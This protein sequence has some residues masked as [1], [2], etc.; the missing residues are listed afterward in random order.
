MQKMK[1]VYDKHIS[2]VAENNCGIHN[3]ICKAMHGYFSKSSF[4]RSETVNSFLQSLAQFPSD[5]MK[6]PR[7]TPNVGNLVVN[8]AYKTFIMALMSKPSYRN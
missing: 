6:H 2:T 5:D 3:L 7:N 8:Y 1:E 4:K